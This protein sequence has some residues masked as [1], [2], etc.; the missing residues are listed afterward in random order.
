[1]TQRSHDGQRDDLVQQERS[2]LVTEA[3]KITKVIKHIKL[4]K[5]TLKVLEKQRNMCLETTKW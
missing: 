3:D 5:E 4:I 2:V 1:M